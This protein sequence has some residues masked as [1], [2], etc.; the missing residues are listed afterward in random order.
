MITIQV[1]AFL[2]DSISGVQLNEVRLLSAFSFDW[3][4]RS[5]SISPEVNATLGCVNRMSGFELNA[6]SYFLGFIQT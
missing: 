3:Q 6:C 4:S 5:N 2:L 1:S